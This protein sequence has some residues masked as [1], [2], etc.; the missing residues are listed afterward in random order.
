VV[1]PE[2]AMNPN[3]PYRRTFYP[4]ARERADAQVFTV[5]SGEQVKGLDIQL[6]EPF[7]T[8]NIDSS[9]EVER[10]PSRR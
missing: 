7:A 1:N 2:Q 3:F 4:S 10:W 9:C 5:Q 6:E 8:A